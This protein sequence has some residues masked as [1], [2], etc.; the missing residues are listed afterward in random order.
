[1]QFLER[2]TVLGTGTVNGSGTAVFNTTSLAAGTHSIAAAYSG[3]QINAA[4]TSAA[5]NVTIVPA[6][7]PNYAMAVSTSNVVL[8]TGQKTNVMVTLTP[9]NGFNAPVTLSCSKLPAGTSCSFGPAT[10]TPNGGPVSSTLSIGM[11]PATSTAALNPAPGGSSAGKT[12]LG[13]VMPW[14]LLSLLGLS[15]K[16]NRSRMAGWSMRLL[17]AVSL[18][19]GSLWISGCGYTQNRSLFTIIVTSSGANVP[20]KT[21]QITVNIAK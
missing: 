4:S 8:K 3:D 16:K 6:G 9:Q 13:L 17:V 20:T 18:I 19:A 11:A 7:T 1:V 21:A 12:A 14:G 15:T 2:A 10:V 5:I